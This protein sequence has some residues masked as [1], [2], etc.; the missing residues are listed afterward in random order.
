[1]GRFWEPQPS[2]PLSLSPRMGLKSNS[3]KEAIWVSTLD[4]DTKIWSL[5]KQ[6]SKAA[7]VYKPSG[8]NGQT[9]Q[10]RF[11]KRPFLQFKYS[12]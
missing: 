6:K 8:P 7:T 12:V 11:T 10:E 1:M 9:H 4:P 3:K 5:K 2:L